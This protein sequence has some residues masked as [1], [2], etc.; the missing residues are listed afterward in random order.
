MVILGIVIVLIALLLAAALILGTSD[1]SV[2]GQEVDIQLFDA[3]TITLTPLTMVIAGMVAMFLLWLGLVLIKTTLTRKAKQKKLRKQ[4]AAEAR[5]REEQEEVARQER[6]RQA[7]LERG[8]Q[9]P[10]AGAPYE[11]SDAGATRPISSGDYARE[12]ATRPVARQDP[13]H[14]TGDA[15]GDATRPI[16][17]G[18]GTP[19][20]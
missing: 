14:A 7:D 6:E 15:T 20:R 19:P 18:E 2:S 9:A 3:V 8:G 12:D 17:R 1:P 11:G 5:E 13:G 4:Q 10:S 16:R